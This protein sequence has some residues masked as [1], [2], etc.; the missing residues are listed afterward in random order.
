MISHISGKI[1]YV[2]GGFFEISA[3]NMGYKIYALPKSLGIYSS[4]DEVEVFTYL[5]VR[6]NA[7]DLYGFFERDERDFFEV[8]IRSD[9]L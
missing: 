3:G 4:G 2:G 1:K 6:D 8:L 5:H 9:F 7:M